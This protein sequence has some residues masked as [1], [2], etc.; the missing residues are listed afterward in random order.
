[1]TESDT[2]PNGNSTPPLDRESHTPG[3]ISPGP[4]NP[5]AEPLRGLGATGRLARCC[6]WVCL[7]A[8]VQHRQ[9]GDSGTGAHAEDE[10]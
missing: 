7:N 8:V 3:A 2:P 10:Q 9:H 5:V 4:R 1:M 6:V